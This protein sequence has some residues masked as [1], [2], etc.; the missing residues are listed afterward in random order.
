LRKSVLLPNLATVETLFLMN[1]Q[2]IPIKEFLHENIEFEGHPDCR[3]N[4]E[5]SVMF[6]SRVG[7]VV[8]WIGYYAS[9]DGAWV[10]S[11]G[12]K[13]RP[14][15]GR[16]EIAY[17]TFPSFQH[18]GIGTMI[19]KELVMLTL[20]TDPTVKI[21]ARTLMEESHSTKILKK[22]GFLWQGVVVDPDDGEVWEWEYVR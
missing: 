18:K 21:T 19:C 1:L 16:V 7:Y 15:D 6:Y 20:R 11:G 8:P 12:F 17:G 9:L 22:N 5:M 3:E 13:G 4:L 2:L 10:G 14:M